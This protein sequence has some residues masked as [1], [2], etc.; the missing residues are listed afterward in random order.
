MPALRS[1]HVEVYVFR[2]R[3]RRVEFLVLRRARGRLAGVWQPVT[4]T[5]ERREAAFAAARREVRE[6]SGLAPKR[7][8]RLEDVLVFFD[9]ESDAL[10]CVPR[11]AAEIAASDRVRL[12]RE[13]DAHAFL[14]AAAAGRRFLW[15]SQRR[16]LVAVREQILAGGATA[17]ALAIAT[18]RT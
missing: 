17:R 10:Q 9:P 2:R 18:R 7:W 11:F 15:R 8:W 16:A 3:G 12:S 13:H 4:G 5:R 1:D 6:E 14:A